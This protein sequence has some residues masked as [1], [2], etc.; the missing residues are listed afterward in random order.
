MVLIIY[1]MILDVYIYIY[2]PGSRVF[3]PL[4]PPTYTPPPPGGDHPTPSHDILWGGAGASPILWGGVGGGVEG[5][6]SQCT[7]GDGLML[8]KAWYLPVGLYG[9]SF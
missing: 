1:L 5:I 9:S 2:D 4:P 8:R 6:Y 7:S 3:G